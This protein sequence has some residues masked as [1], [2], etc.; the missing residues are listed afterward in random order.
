MK[1][2]IR[3]IAS[4]ALSGV[5]LAGCVTDN[6]TSTA[7]VNAVPGLGGSP[8]ANG[9]AGASG[10][11]PGSI[12][13]NASFVAPNGNDANP[14]TISQPYRTIQKCATT[15]ASGST[16]EVRAGTYYETVTPNSGVT[17]TSYDG[18]TVTVDGTD[19]VTGWTIHE[20]SIYKASIA[21]S[22]GDTNQVFVGNE[23][24][25]EARYPNGNDLFHVNWATAQAGTSSTR[26]VDSN[27]PNVNWTGAKVHLWSGTDPW[28]PETGAV[29]ASQP[30]QVT[31]S[32]D[33]SLCPSVCAT[34]GGYYYIFGIL[35]ALDTEREW[36]YDPKVATLYF[37]APGN[38]DPNTLPVRAKQR[39]Y[40]FDLSGKSKVTIQNINL[41]ASTINSNASSTSNTIDGIQAQY[42]SHFTAL[43]GNRGAS[44]WIDH[45][46]DTGIV[47]NGRGNILQNSTIAYSAGNGVA[48]LGAD[49]IVKNNLIHHI[50]YIGNYASG[51]ALAG[52]GHT[53][54]NN[55]I[56]D[57]GRSAIFPNAVPNEAIPPSNNNI[58]YNNLYNGMMLSRDGGEIYDAEDAV[59][60]TRIH[61]NWIHDAQSLTSGSASDFPV[62][63]VYLDSGASGFEV[64]QN[65]VWNT[66]HESIYLHGGGVST[67]NNNHVHNNSVP[68]VNSGAYIWLF[69]IPNCGS[70]QVS[71]NL[72]LVPITQQSVKPPCTA[73]SN[74]AT[75]P[76]A[77]EM[78]ASVQ[79]G[80]NFAG[81]S[82]DAPPAIVG[83]TV[84][85]SIAKQPGPLAVLVG[86][87]ATFRV[88]GAGS[89]PLAYQWKK[90]GIEVN[91]ATS[92]TY[93]TPPA[94]SA[95]N[96][97]VFTVQVRNAA[98]IALSAPATLSAE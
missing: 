9:T 31:I 82:S 62:A 89:A 20:G 29:T 36:F 80:C 22:A 71:D 74:G 69:Q 93:T 26:L 63:G 19:A 94:T 85:A 95:D 10:T 25:T 16:C 54:Q 78:N 37:W 53:I 81:C 70:T 73:T 1:T 77:T 24:M 17:I 48:V 58:G 92:T 5:L 3:L 44:Y 84:A 18:E 51:V 60:G 88:T 76:G 21:M 4:C 6:G 83:N 40:A 55:T 35:A 86:Q 50:D 32:V 59:T 56:Y 34:A 15:V 68:D 47:V 75:A 12:P 96:G 33:T 28:T 41:F 66:E 30:G 38:V 23:M 65:V 57:S 8:I 27:L 11:V 98:G 13:A 45:L 67:P 7:S 43:P 72:V 90:N 39:Q 61:H 87:T 42:V 97:V 79:V 46:T 52:N 2:L 64:D 49:N 14:G 91:G